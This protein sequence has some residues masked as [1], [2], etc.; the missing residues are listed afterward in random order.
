MDF[1]QPK[2]FGIYKD[3]DGNFV[4]YKNKGDGTRAERYRGKDEAYAVN[5]IYQKLRSEI[6][7]LTDTTAIIITI[8]TIHGSG[9]MTPEII[10]RRLPLTA[11]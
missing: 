3:S 6:Q 9:T 10:G 4:V 5:E 7:I 2:A 11:S 1:R 8:R